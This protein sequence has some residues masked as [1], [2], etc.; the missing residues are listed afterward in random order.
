MS[1]LGHRAWWAV[2]GHFSA[3]LVF[4]LEEDLEEYIFGQGD[5]YLRCIELHSHT[6]I[7]LEQWFTATGQ[8]RVTLVGPLQA[9][10]W[11]V[12]MVWSLGSRDHFSRARGLE[13]LRRVRSQPLTKDDLATSS[14]MHQTPGIC[15]L[16]AGL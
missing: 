4:Y 1:S 14:K 11:L 2:P 6:L 3:P 8:T 9:R 7:Q 13:M 15:L 12:D 10:Q 5:A 16:L